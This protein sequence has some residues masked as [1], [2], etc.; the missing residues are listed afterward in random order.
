M[1]PWQ[2]RIIQGNTAADTALLYNFYVTN[3][4][5]YYERS[6]RKIGPRLHERNG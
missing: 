1:S 3:V 4:T 5:I 6:V 2:I